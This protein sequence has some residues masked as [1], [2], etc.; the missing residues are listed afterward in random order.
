MGV[1]KHYQYRTTRRKSIEPGQECPKEECFPL[2]RR[3]LQRGGRSRA[4]NSK[5]ISKD[6]DCIRGEALAVLAQ[7]RFKT[8]EPP[9]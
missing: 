1:F 9:F 3:H 5:Q 6:W 2:L 4:R 7:E 8:L